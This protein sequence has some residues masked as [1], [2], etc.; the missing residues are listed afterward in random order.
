MI[1]AWPN[2]WYQ[3]GESYNIIVKTTPT[4]PPDS[5][6]FEMW[7]FL[8]LIFFFHKIFISIF[9]LC[10]LEKCML[11]YIIICNE[12]WTSCTLKKKNEW[13]NKCH[14][15]NWFT[16]DMTICILF[17]VCDIKVDKAVFD[18]FCIF[19]FQ[20]E[21]AGKLIEAVGNEAPF[22]GPCVWI[23]ER[24]RMSLFLTCERHKDTKKQENLRWKHEHIVLGTVTTQKPRAMSAVGHHSIFRLTEQRNQVT[25]LHC[26][27]QINMVLFS[28]NWLT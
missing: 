20:W 16:V 2:Q 28:M 14:S 12:H 24:A 13:M 9:F 1:S 10:S 27:P 3:W 21:H 15:N 19:C 25:Q 4:S 5:L 26:K 7:S 23:Y 6:S 22:C 11:Y 8:Y 18:F 17:G